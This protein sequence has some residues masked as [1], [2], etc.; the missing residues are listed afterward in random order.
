VL[1]VATIHAEPI[2]CGALKFHEDLTAELKRMWVAPSVRGLGVGRNLLRQLESHALDRGIRRL[3]LETNKTLVEAIDL[4][5]TSGYKEVPAFNSEP[6]AD[7]WFEKPLKPV[8][9]ASPSALKADPPRASSRPER[10]R[11]NG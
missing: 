8:S 10:R 6:Y 2:G 5:R 7:H 9:K 1:L 4:Y 3:R 11:R